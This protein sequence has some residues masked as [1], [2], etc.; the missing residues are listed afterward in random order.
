[1]KPDNVLLDGEGHLRLSDFGISVQLSAEKHWMTRGRA[2]TPGLPLLLCSFACSTPTARSDRRLPLV[3]PFLPSL[4]ALVT[5][6][7]APELLENQWYGVSPDVWSFG[8]TVYELL[9]RKRPFKAI[10]PNQVCGCGACFVSVAPCF[11]LNASLSARVQ[12]LPPQYFDHI[13]FS[14]RI[15]PAARDFISGLLTVDLKQRL[16]YKKIGWDWEKVKRHPFFQG[17]DWNAIAN[18]QIK[19]P[20]QPDTER[21]NCPGDHDLE[22]RTAPHRII[23]SFVAC[24]SAYFFV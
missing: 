24:I 16:G 1:M 18:K 7:Q 13:A 5:G 22:G 2:G 15:S 14:D 23:A 8:V 17:V 10:K 20:V 6:Y 19:P 3:L 9:H 21:A 4:L 11:V 12:D